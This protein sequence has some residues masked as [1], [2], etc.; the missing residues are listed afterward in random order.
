[1]KKRLILIAAI[2]LAAALLALPAAADGEIVTETDANGNLW[3]YNS[4]ARTLT[5]TGSGEIP[6]A[7]SLQFGLLATSLTIGEGITEIGDAV[8]P[9]IG[10]CPFSCQIRLK[11]LGA[12]RFIRALFSPLIYRKAWSALKARLAAVYHWSL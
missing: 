4:E 7:P 3:T 11:V 1:M 6:G 10:F 9:T 12:R 5:I 2:C 8:F